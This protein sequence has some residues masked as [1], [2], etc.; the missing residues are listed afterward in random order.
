MTYRAGDLADLFEDGPL[1]DATVED[2]DREDRRGWL[3]RTEAGEF[4]EPEGGAADMSGVL[5]SGKRND[6]QRPG[7]LYLQEFDPLV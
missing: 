1:A 3:E 4:G 6:R 5:T 7:I 2:A